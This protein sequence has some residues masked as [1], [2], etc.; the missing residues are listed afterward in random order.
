MAPSVLQHPEC[1][2]HI[3]TGD[4]VA[5]CIEKGTT[6][7]NLPIEAYRAHSELFAD[8]IY[9]SI[10]LEACVERRLSAGGPGQASVEAQ[11]RQVRDFINAERA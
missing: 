2:P 8:D 5:E 6:L 9:D 4:L 11:I 3:V 7:E 10:S 1:L